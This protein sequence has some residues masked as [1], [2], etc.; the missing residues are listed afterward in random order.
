MNAVA[1]MLRTFVEAGVNTGTSIGNARCIRFTNIWVVLWAPLYL[2]GMLLGLNAGDTLFTLVALAVLLLDLSIV[3][4]NSAGLHIVS[5]TIFTVVPNLF[6]VFC[7]FYFPFATFLPFYLLVSVVG[8]F[9]AFP[10]GDRLF[11]LRI[12]FIV[13]CYCVINLFAQNSTPVFTLTQAQLTTARYV[14]AIVG[15]LSLVALGCAFVYSITIAEDTTGKEHDKAELL[16]KNMLPQKI[17]HRLHESPGTIADKFS[18]VTVMFIDIVNFTP[19]SARMTPM[20]T[21]GF[22]N[23][24][25][26]ALDTI[27]DR[28]G[29]EKIKTIGDAYMVAAGIPQPRADHAQAVAGMALDVMALAAAMKPLMENGLAFRIGI[30][31][32]PVVAGIIGNRKFSYD[33][34]G[35]SVNTAARMESHGVPGRI[36]VTQEVR[37]RLSERFD[38]E[39]RGEVN[40][41]GKGPMPVWLLN[42]SLQEAVAAA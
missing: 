35:D 4:F 15:L 1:G 37:D 12:A 16:L 18:E 38:F 26:S 3:L 8:V 23:E 22:L 39:Y 5:R 24:I 25:F 42:G 9:L 30:N 32:G 36:Q 11:A 34:W 2:A 33:L 20:M 6:I 40:V 21:A 17:I 29:L 14:T 10:F 7:S 31:T 28:H 13:A 19:A 41:K 27:A